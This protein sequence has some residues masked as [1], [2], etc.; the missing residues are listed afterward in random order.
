M[1]VVVVGLVVVLFSS[2]LSSSSISC[3]CFDA[4]A[5][6]AVVL[7]WSW[8]LMT[9]IVLVRLYM[10]G[11]FETW[12]LASRRLETRTS[13][14]LGLGLGTWDHEDSVFVTYEAWNWDVQSA[15][16]IDRV[17]RSPATSAPV[18]QIFIHIGLLT[19]ANRAR[20]GDNM[21]SQFV[22]LRCNNKL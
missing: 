15:T 8:F 17:F 5:A 12:V 22:Y 11:V 21:L 1:V 16:S 3:C 14:G 4:A 13:L 18:E 2:R 19:R 20:M 9:T 6:A 7:L 10:L